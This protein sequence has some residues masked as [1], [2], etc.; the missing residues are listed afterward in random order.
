MIRE[1]G[2]GNSNQDDSQ[3]FYPCAT[4]GCNN[5]V[6]FTPEMEEKFRQLGFTDANGNVTKPKYCR[7]CKER[8][9]QERG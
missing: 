2:S 4:N 5:M 6:K 7:D 9:K 8:R 3:Y 1:F